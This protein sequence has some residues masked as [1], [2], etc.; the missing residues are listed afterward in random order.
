MFSTSRD[1][2]VCGG[3]SGGQGIRGEEGSHG[4]ITRPLKN[5]PRGEKGK[6]EG[7]KGKGVLRRMYRIPRNRVVKIVGLG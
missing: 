7:E 2:R 6:K 1:A 3:V 5:E 4:R